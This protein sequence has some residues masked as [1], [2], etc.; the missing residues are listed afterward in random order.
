[1]IKL[2][3]RGLLDNI[4]I[5]A[6]CSVSWESMTGDEKKRFCRHCRLNV[7]NISEMSSAEAQQLLFNSD[8]SKPLCVRLYRRFDGTVITRNCPVGLKKI[9]AHLSRFAQAIGVAALWIFSCG[10]SVKASD[11]A[12]LPRRAQKRLID[13]G[14]KPNVRPVSEQ[15]QES[16]AQTMGRVEGDY[17]SYMKSINSRILAGWLTTSGF[18]LS[19]YRVVIAFKILRDGSASSI[20]VLKSCGVAQYDV[21]ALESVRNAGP[22]RPL[23][24]FASDPAAVEFTFDNRLSKDFQGNN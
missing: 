19:K 9:R 16:S 1:M 14:V 8:S 4:E 21:I 7:Y 11:A 24:G 5:A 23:P 6:P 3:S 10:S 15:I 17:A 12:P 2:N 18:D 22:F 20:R 13:F